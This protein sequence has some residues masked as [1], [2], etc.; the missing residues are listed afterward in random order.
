M[1]ERCVNGRHYLVTP[2]PPLETAI[3]QH[4]TRDPPTDGTRGKQR[5]Y[6]TTYNFDVKICM[7]KESVHILAIILYI[8]LVLI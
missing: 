8:F 7:N 2:S 4:A 1:T 3:H 6:L 5:P